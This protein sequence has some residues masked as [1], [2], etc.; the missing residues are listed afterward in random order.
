MGFFFFFRLSAWSSLFA[1]SP[2]IAGERFGN[3]VEIRTVRFQ[4]AEPRVS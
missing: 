4:I 1:A 2:L 3:T